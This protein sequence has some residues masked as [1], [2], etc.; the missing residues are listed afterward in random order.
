[1][2]EA[3]LEGTASDAEG[4]V[5]VVISID[6]GALAPLALTA[7]AFS[8]IV[9]LAGATT[10][11]M[12]RA[13]D[14]AGLVTEMTLELHR[15]AEGLLDDSFGD[16]VLPADGT[17]DTFTYRD[18]ANNNDTIEAGVLDAQGRT[19]AVGLSR[20]V[21]GNF[22]IIAWRFTEDGLLDTT[23]GPDVEPAD[24]TPDGFIALDGPAGGT[25][26]NDYGRAV[27]L[28]AAG[29]I[30]VVGTSGSAATGEDMLI[31][32]LTADGLLDTTFGD[33]V[34]PMDG[35]PD[36]FTAHSITATSEDDARD[37]V[38][39]ADGNLLVVGDFADGATEDVAVWK[40][41]DA[42]LLDTT[43][44]GGDGYVTVAD[45]AGVGVVD[46]GLAMAL[47][48]YGRMLLAGESDG[49]ATFWRLTAAGELD[50]TF[51]ADVNPADGT[52]D[53]FSVFTFHSGRATDLVP[54][55][56]GRVVATGYVYVDTT[57]RHDMALWRYLSDGTPD[58]GFGS[59]YDMTP[60]PDGFSRHHSAAGNT[61]F[62]GG[63]G[64]ALDA[65]GN[66]LI[67]GNSEGPTSDPD[68]TVWRYTDAGALDLTF[69]G[70]INP[71][72]GTPD[73]F[74]VETE[75]SGGDNLEHGRSLLL[76]A[77]GRIVVTGTSY[78]GALGGA[79]CTVWRLR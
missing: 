34:L 40:F 6:D 36:G 13:T 42:G 26:V 63:Y 75:A 16:D 24:G 67:V 15:I 70:D 62:D 11:V 39:D 58:L 38:I 76:D 7:G 32:R 31:A 23:F 65:A 49:R 8:Q 3:T 74:A 66:I 17:P 50:A 57:N 12:L 21:A 79:N 55:A 19:I 28:D 9:P 14:D 45:A 56:S 54:D 48:G 33:D 35:T 53:G 68:L 44:G 60:G 27:V 1:M 10:S 18:R 41:T 5:E 59:D 30:I 61:H 73:G 4:G 46:L 2:T 71:M 25:G 20:G 78:N 22:D 37:V 43:F 69:G 51:G 29:R 64:L 52:P 77:A 72:D 47:D